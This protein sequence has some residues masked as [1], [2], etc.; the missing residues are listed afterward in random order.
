L[1]SSSDDLH[2]SFKRS[3]GMFSGGRLTLDLAAADLPPDEAAAWDELSRAGA[4]EPAPAADY[5]AADEY[6][7]DV[8]LRRGDAER[9]LTFTDGT[10]PGD[11]APFVRRLER[12][13]E[14]EA[15][16]RRGR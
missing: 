9:R 5:G 15:R 8:T 16:R 7:Y 14:E 11:L 6:Q 1:A 12:R 13:A 3:G 2:L 10:L 4:P